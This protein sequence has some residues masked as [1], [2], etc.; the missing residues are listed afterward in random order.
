MQS[1]TNSFSRSGHNYF[2]QNPP[3]YP[4]TFTVMAASV[5]NTVSAPD[6]SSSSSEDDEAVRRCREAV[7]KQSPAAGQKG[8]LLGF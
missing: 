8:E 2:T 7:W 3:L 4:G 1:R 6:E 5:K